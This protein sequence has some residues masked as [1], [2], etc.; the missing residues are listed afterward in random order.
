MDETALRT[1]YWEDNRSR[2][3]FPLWVVFRRIGHEAGRADG[4]PYLRPSGTGVAEILKGLEAL[5][6]I[7][8]L[9]RELAC[10]EEELRA[11]LWYLT[12][13]VERLP[14]PD[15]WAEWN[16]RVDQAWEAGWFRQHAGQDA[17]LT[18]QPLPR[19]DGDG[20]RPVF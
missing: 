16:R 6:T 10:T 14:A 12:W 17:G 15:S 19:G 3:D 9:A 5:P 8:T 13:L 4:H 2:R 20:S 1:A 11:T 18:G 7:P